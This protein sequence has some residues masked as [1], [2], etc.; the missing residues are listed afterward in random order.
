MKNGLAWNNY[1]KVSWL[2]NQKYP[3]GVIRSYVYVVAVSGSKYF[4]AV[5]LV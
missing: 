2:R 4:V 5:V 1:P 3:V